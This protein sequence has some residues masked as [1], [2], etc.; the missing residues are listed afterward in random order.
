MQN[1]LLVIHIIA[2]IVM[3]AVIMLQKSE[4]GALGIGGGGGGGL[5]TGRGAAGALVRVTMIVGAV[6]FFTS[7]GLTRLANESLDTRSDVERQVEAEERDADSGAISDESLTPL[8][9][10]LDTSLSLDGPDQIAPALDEVAPATD[11]ATEP[12][13]VDNPQ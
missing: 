1:V 6:F 3:T 13:P 5:M 7:L 9:D 12:E 4:G 2:C 11:G 10:E 8:L